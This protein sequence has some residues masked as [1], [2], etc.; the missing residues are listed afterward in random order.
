MLIK[1]LTLVIK[2]FE[3]VFVGMIRF[4]YIL[5]QVGKYYPRYKTVKLV[6]NPHLIYIHIF[7]RLMSERAGTCPP[8]KWVTPS[9]SLYSINVFFL[10]VK[11]HTCIFLPTEKLRPTVR[12]QAELHDGAVA[13]TEI[14]PKRIWKSN[15][16]KCC[17][18]ITYC[19][20]LKLLLEFCSG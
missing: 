6:L 15:L 2:D 3:Y 8:W 20:L 17:L 9:Y 16:P 5:R 13:I 12:Y 11:L 4:A 10:S 19:Q 7:W 14:R 18:P 1:A